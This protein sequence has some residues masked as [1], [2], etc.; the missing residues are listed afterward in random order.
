LSEPY[1]DE[2][3]A[4]I[5]DPAPDSPPAIGS[6]AESEAAD[7]RPHGVWIDAWRVLRRKPIFVISV[8]IIV[9]LAVMAIA[10][11]L[12]ASGDPNKGVLAHSLHGPSAS[13]WFGYDVNG[14]NVWTRV[15]YGARASL[16]VG[17]TCTLGTSLIGVVLG[18]VAAYAG[19]IV[20][21][22][23][24]RIA[25]MLLGIPFAL[26]AIIVLSSLTR[27][28]TPNWQVEIILILTIIGFGWPSIS[29]VL[30][31]TV[32]STRHADYVIAGQAL[33]LSGT[34]VLFRHILPNAISPI[35]VLS[36]M[37]VGGYIATEASLSY[38]GLG[39]RPPAVSW[40]QMVSDGQ[41]YLRSGF[42]VLLFPS[43]FLAITILAFVLAGEALR[44]ALNP[45]TR[46]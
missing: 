11:S 2:L 19:G 27:F 31:A 25:D 45:T 26:A 39:L 4:E 29:R 18:A 9:V 23:I 22:I 12:F 17:F 7:N 43:I 21:T 8:V 13:A 38:L 28:T 14:R 24:S 32:L 41:P 20:D 46:R 35:L 40:G 15:V 44:E 36:T 3:T 6:L 33:G 42:H 37:R 1:L 34:R 30:R 5:S 16:I 10:P